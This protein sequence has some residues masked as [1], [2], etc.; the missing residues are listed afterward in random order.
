MRL[1]SIKRYA[2]GYGVDLLPFWTGAPP[3]FSAMLEIFY[4]KLLFAG[5]HN[6]EILMDIAT[7]MQRIR[8]TGPLKPT[9]EVLRALHQ[10]HMFTVPFENL[11][12]HLGRPIILE[13]EALYHKIVEEKRGGFCYELN[14]LF[15]S[16]LKELGFTVDLLSAQVKSQSGFGAPFDHLLLLVHL[17]ED[18]LADV[19]FGASFLEPLRLCE[20]VQTQSSGVYRLEI[21]SPSTLFLQRAPDQSWTIEHRFTLHPYA[22]SDFDEM[23]HYHQTSPASHFTR[24]RVCTR[25]TLGGRLT[26]SEQRLIVTSSGQRQERALPDERAYLAALREHFD[27]HLPATTVW[28]QNGTQS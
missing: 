1:G 17:E 8:Y 12:I 22:L 28:L 3:R 14:G 4:E 23:C 21:G 25:A 24:Q 20:D 7:Y 18:W 19:G 26:L 15:A 9:L 5:Q 16:L 10:A 11:D 2:P 27:I 13:P 6:E